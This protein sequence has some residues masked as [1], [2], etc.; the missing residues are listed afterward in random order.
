MVADHSAVERLLKT[1][2]GQLDGVLKMIDDDRYC[3]DISNQILS[4]LAILR[5]A[6]RLVVE[7][8]L[9]SCVK[10]AFQKQDV[11]EQEEKISEIMDL[12]EK[13]TK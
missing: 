13:M 7:S 4:V 1:A 11:R 3:M 10:Q 12:L 5:K 2:R 6:N 9:G 8:H